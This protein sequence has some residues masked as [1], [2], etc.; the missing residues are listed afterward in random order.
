MPVSSR[1]RKS[2]ASDSTVHGGCDGSPETTVAKLLV[3][4]S[5]LFRT[6]STPPVGSSCVLHRVLMQ[7]CVSDGHARLGALTSF[8]FHCVLV[9]R[10]F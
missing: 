2:K 5:V 8:S 10:S 3:L 9:P 4:Q 1:T 6:P 7:C